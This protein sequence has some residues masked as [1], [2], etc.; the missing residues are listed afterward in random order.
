MITHYPCSLFLFC[1]V[2]RMWLQCKYLHKYI[3]VYAG[4]VLSA[5]WC[6]IHDAV[7]TLAYEAK[8]FSSY[9]ML[10]F[11][12]KYGLKT[13]E[14]Q[15]IVIKLFF[16]QYIFHYLWLNREINR[17][18]PPLFPLNSFFFFF[19]FRMFWPINKSSEGQLEEIQEYIWRTQLDLH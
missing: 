15:L 1:I 2:V 9:Y 19:F 7:L 4:Q 5:S 12:V 14:E 8:R 10:R 3:W 17:R 18:S 11:I 16:L 6:H 13:K